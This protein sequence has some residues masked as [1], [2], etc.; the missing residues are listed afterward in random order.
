MVA[1]SQ[2]ETVGE[3]TLG[4]RSHQWSLPKFSAFLLIIQHAGWPVWGVGC[5]R[6]E[7]L[8][9]PRKAIGRTREGERERERETVIVLAS[10]DAAVVI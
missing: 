2:E 9:A 5:G 8:D 10:D 3:E 7:V 6:N 4:W 1:V